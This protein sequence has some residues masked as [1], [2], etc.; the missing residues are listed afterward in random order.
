MLRI[1]QKTPAEMDRAFTEYV[2]LFRTDTVLEQRME[3][4]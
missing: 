2:R 4:Y 1:Y 3:N